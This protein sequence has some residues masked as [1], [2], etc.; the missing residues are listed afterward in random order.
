MV[1][2]LVSKNDKEKKRIFAT[3]YNLI[4]HGKFQH[5]GGTFFTLFC[6]ELARIHRQVD[7]HQS[8]HRQESAFYV[9]SH[10]GLYLRNH[11]Q[12]AKQL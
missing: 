4:K 10:F 2:L 7:T 6:S 5:L 12:S 3:N 11:T 1:L 9:T 8:G